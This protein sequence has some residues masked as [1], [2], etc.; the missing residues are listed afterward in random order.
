M[1][2]LT[3]HAYPHE[4]ASLVRYRWADTPSSQPGST[5]MFEHSA[6]PEVGV[7]ERFFSVCYQ[8]SLLHEEGRLSTFRI[9]LAGPEVFPAADGPPTGLHRLVLSQARPFEE[10]ELQRLAR[11]A[12]FPRA[13]IGVQLDAH[14][15]LE[16]WGLIHSGPRWLQAVRGG[17]RVDQPV[18]PVL[19][20][21]V[22]GPGRVLASQGTRILAALAGGTVTGVST[23]VFEAS[24]LVAVFAELHAARV[25]DQPGGDEPAALDHEFGH[26][27]VQHVLRRI[28]STVRATRHGGT[29]IFLPSREAEE[30]VVCG[31]YLTLKYQFRDEEPRRRTF[32]IMVEIMTELSRMRAGAVGQDPSSSGWSDYEAS[33]DPLLAS[34]DEALFEVAH[35]VAMLADVDGAVVMTNRLEILGFG[36]EISGTLADV[37]SV[38]RSLD[39][40]GVRRSTERAD[41]V[42]T[43][44]RSAYRLC[45]ALHDAFIIVVSQDG[46]VRFARWLDGAVTYF[47]QLATGPWEV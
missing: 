7:V 6:L 43:R 1:Q 12:A 11:A 46:G 25:T 8:A 2:R 45:Q 10:H 30:L 19:M 35:L 40:E 23:D 27:L 37:E 24:W 36:A 4:L 34:L 5:G 3:P 41:R 18:P 47:D 14:G 20:A 44:H 13:L 9:V 29:L 15:Q 16:V 31:R 17:R 33:N 38:D 42:G 26:H 21:A 28:V 39:L 32:S 22:S